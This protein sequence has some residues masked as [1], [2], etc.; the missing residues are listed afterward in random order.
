MALPP[1]WVCHLADW[2][3][4]ISGPVVQQ[5]AVLVA[6]DRIVAS[7][8]AEAILSRCRRGE[9]PAA[10]RDLLLYEHAGGAIMPALVNAHTHLEFGALR[11][12]IPPQENLPA[13]LRAAM[14]GLAEITPEEIEAAVTAGLAELLHFGTVL[15]AEVSNTGQSLAALAAS[16]LEFHYF[17]ECLG[18]NLLAEGPLAHDFPLLGRPE[19]ASLPLSAAA[20]APYSVSPALCRRIKEFNRLLGRPTAIH[21]AESREEVEFCQQ[22]TGP[23]QQLLRE[24]GRWYAAFVPPAA[25]PAVYLEKLGFWDAETLA[26]HCLYLGEAERAIL[27]RH[28]VTV[29]L[30]PRSNRYTGAGFPDLPALRQAGIRWALGTDSLASTP[31]LNLFQEIRELHEAYPEVPLSELFAAATLQGAVALKRHDLGSLAPGKQ[32]ALLWLPVPAGAPVW[33]ALLAAGCA[34]DIWWLTPEGKQ[35]VR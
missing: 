15:V 29:V 30:C 8:P 31:D 28:R 12:Q 21:L 2:L 35:D 25:P 27:A 7:G 9:F 18:F 11:G 32:A 22:G 1:P 34:G 17:Y 10:S 24:R 20:H 3:V 4:P 13:W 23:L 19:I 16:P 33:E 5:G 14:E 26:V 6:G